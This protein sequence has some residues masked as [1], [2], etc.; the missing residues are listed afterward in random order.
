MT[1]LRTTSPSGRDRF[2]TLKEFV[3]GKPLGHP[4][5]AMFVHFPVAFTIG[6]LAFDLLSRA[7]RFPEAPLAATWLIV[8][9]FAGAA[10]AVVTGL[11]D[12]WGMAPGSPKRTVA[13]RHMLFQVAAMA[14]FVAAF[15]LR[16]S[17]RRAPEAH[18]VWIALEAAGV[19]V[20]L[21]GQ[22]LG[23]VLV[24]RMGMRVSTAQ[25]RNPQERAGGPGA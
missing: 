24:Y 9:A 22:W 7:G 14:A 11:V 5:H 18:P 23:G 2:W 10:P 15:A 4:S 6:A 20:M 12:W 17:D 25:S 19:A 3:Q 8:G 16:W 1:L 13:T 21:A